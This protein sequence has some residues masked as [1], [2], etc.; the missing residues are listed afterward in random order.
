[1]LPASLQVEDVVLGVLASGLEVPDPPIG[2]S[3]RHDTRARASFV[4]M[5]GVS[6]LAAQILSHHRDV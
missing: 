4:L 1:M 6:Y 5:A 3:Q 2:Q